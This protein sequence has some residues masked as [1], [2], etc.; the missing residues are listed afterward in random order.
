MTGRSAAWLWGVDVDG[1]DGAGRGS[2]VEVTV[3]AAAG[4]RVA[5]IVVRRRALDPASVG[6]V[7]WMRDVPALWPAYAALELAADP[8]RTHAEAVV[9]LD[10]FCESAPVT[11]RQLSTLAAGV[12]GRG[13][14]RLAA[15][16]ADAD[17]LAGSPPETRLRLAMAAAGLPQ[18]V[19]Q[20]RLTTVSGRLVKTL[21][22]AW[23]HL[24]FAVE[25]DGA[26]HVATS[27]RAEAP[28][29]LPK[30]R[31][32]LNEVQELGWQLFYVTAP[33]PHEMSGLVDRI[34]A[35]LS[36]RAAA[37]GVRLH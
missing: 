1:P 6:C 30:D 21:D 29:R 22:F 25:Y 24:R 11:L 8:A 37:L 36:S 14:R 35:A 3:P 19:A 9:V 34:R 7:P 10:Q 16:L 26:G 20:F 27:T 5:G 15:A 2:A 4:R 31:R 28:F 13:C 12:R 18:P 23:P 32:V 33:D 17:G